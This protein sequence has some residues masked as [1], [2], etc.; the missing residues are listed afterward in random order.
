MK[1]AY[2][3]FENGV[4]IQAKSFG[5]DGTQVGEVVF[6]TSMSG[7]QEIITDPS[8]A[9]QFVTFT[10]PE[11]GIVGTNPQDNERDQTHCKG[12]FV[13]QYQDFHSSF[14]S[15]ESLQDFLKENNIMGICDF[16]TRGMT[17]M[18]RENGSMMTIVST[19]ISCKDELEQLL[20]S[21]KR[22]EEINYI[23][24]V[25]IKSQKTHTQGTFCFDRFDY[26]IPK[27]HKTVVAIDF[28][29]KD[30]ILNELVQSGLN[31]ILMPHDFK[32]SEI[33][34]LFDAG[35][36]HGVFLSNGPGDPM[37]LNKEIDEIKKL[38][39]RKIP[40]FGI[41]LGHQLLSIAHG[42][43]TEKLKFGHH[44]GNHP[45][46]N[47]KTGSVEITAQNHNYSVTDEIRKVA[48]VTHINLFDGTIEG[49]RY[50]DSPIF[51]VQYHPEASPGPKDS[52]Q[53]FREF[54]QML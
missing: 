25:S 5:S 37:V 10:M 34:S 54:A 8:Y 51:S 17:K 7:Y 20:K 19:E 43:P 22:I 32:A 26:Q 23:Q 9:G 38:I 2:I 30:N 35:K 28:G 16:D 33:I 12:I 31:T 39:E 21:S 46:K 11:I 24:E 41:C 52:T 40:M 4:F 13:R 47:L 42:Y 49:V 14:R 36:I 53:L 44:G 3:Y 48:E 45:V 29:A 1:T 27:T 15:K 50:K 6:N 18:I